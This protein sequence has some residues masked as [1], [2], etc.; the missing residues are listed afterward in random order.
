M[1]EI[2]FPATINKVQT[3]ADGGI[4]VSL[5]LSEDCIPQGAMLMEIRRQGIPIVVEIRADNG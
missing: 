4:R 2:T 1:I 5:D 3:L